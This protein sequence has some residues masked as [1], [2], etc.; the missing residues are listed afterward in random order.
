MKNPIKF[1]IAVTILVSSAW[2][3]TTQ[4]IGNDKIIGKAQVI[5]SIMLQNKLT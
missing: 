5:Q 4:N 2:S 1:F 3:A